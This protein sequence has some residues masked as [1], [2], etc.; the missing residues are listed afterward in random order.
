MPRAPRYAELAAALRQAITS[1]AYTVGDQL[2]TESALC[3]THDV[4]RHTARAALRLLETDGLIARKPG[5]GT[6]V[7]STAPS[8]AFIQPVD[9]LDD[10]MQ[11]AHDAVLRIAETSQGDIDPD[12]ARRLDLP[13]GSRWLR[14]AGDRRRGEDVVAL[15]T[16]YVAE[17]IGAHPEDFRAAD[18][19]VTEEIERIYGVAPASITQTIGAE[20][21]GDA[22]ALRL[23]VSAPA[24]GLRTARKYFDAAG[25]LYV[26][27]DSLHPADRFAYRMA[28]RKRAF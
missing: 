27:S 2:P 23:G 11:Y 3:A 22:D 24:A 20:L 17:R 18:R 8:Q 13:K 19:A 7:V 21:I 16:I 28:Y 9:G 4:S 6:T 14:L 12:T 26:V 10:L 15:T 25:D 1:G 5:L